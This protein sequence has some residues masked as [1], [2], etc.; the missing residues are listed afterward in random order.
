[1]KSLLCTEQASIKS[2]QLNFSFIYCGQVQFLEP[3]KKKPWPGLPDL[4]EKY[5]IKPLYLNGFILLLY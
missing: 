4:H 2:V 3:W 1:M 5:G